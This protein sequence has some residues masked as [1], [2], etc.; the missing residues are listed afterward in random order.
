MSEVKRKLERIRQFMDEQSLEALLLSRVSSFAWATCGAA[1]YMNVAAT[2]GEASL[3]ITLNN[4]F[5]ITN[6]IEVP[7]LDQEENLKQQGWEF[8]ISPWYEADDTVSNLV[9]NSKLG[10]DMPYPG[11]KN[12]SLELSRARS[13]LTDEEGGRFREL[14]RRCAEAMQEAVFAVK[15]GQ[16][17]HEIAARM[18][19]F[20]QA[21]GVQV[22]VSLVATDERIF[23]FRHPLPTEKKLE[24][25]VMLIFCGRWKGLV[26]S[27][28]RLV[29]F[30]LL[31][32]VI[33]EKSFAVAEVDARIIA[34]TRPG[35]SLGDIFRSVQ[36]AYAASG[37]PE[38]WTLHHQ[39]GPAGYEPREYIATPGSIDV[40]KLGQV[41]A[42]NPSITGT[43]SEDTILVG[44]NENEILTPMGD[45]PTLSVEVNG[46]P[47][48]R[49]A[50]LEIT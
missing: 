11:S 17:E 33:K 15:P 16:T 6:N 1:S 2:Q 27:I 48:H 3:L 43:K 30:G 41:Y 4:H 42:W 24:H 12:I 50:I 36:A 18:I 31:P 29:H 22:T 13:Q 26:C 46:Q 45:W 5:L 39:G 14:G 38:E 7:R 28:T 34:E 37:F 47:Y 21:R 10:A 20:V 35:V 23:S 32:K 19:E 9:D 8:R 44:E 49:P 40:V 25:Y